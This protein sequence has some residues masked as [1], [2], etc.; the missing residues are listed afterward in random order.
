MRETLTT[1]CNQ[2]AENKELIKEAFTWERTEMYPV[3]AAVF[4]DKGKTADVEKMKACKAI[5]KEQTGVFSD[6][7]GNG[8]LALISMLALSADP[9]AKMQD[10]LQM[11]SKLKEHFWSSAYLP[12]AAMVV[13]NMAEVE[14]YDELAART[15]NIYDLMK[16]EHP[17]LTSGEDSV[18][19]ALLAFSELTDQQVVAEMERCYRILKPDFFSGNA[20]QSLSHVLALGEGSAEQK[21]RRV[22]SLYEGLRTKGCKYGTDYELATLGVLAL[23]PVDDT[24]IINE[25][26]EV[27]NFL[28]EQKGYGLFGYTKK[29]RLMHASMLVSSSYMENSENPAMNTAAISGTISMIAAQQAAM[30]AVIASTS[31][32]AAASSN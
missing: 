18:F 27:D 23:L 12:V 11:H 9:K 26:V 7:R 29:Q 30:C 21:C 24:T 25:M 16:N 13:A 32:A 5:L 17:F 4:A 31:A 1:L 6:F 15:K 10:A 8:L 19:A 3:C 22:M 2:F 28:A 14:K 20:V